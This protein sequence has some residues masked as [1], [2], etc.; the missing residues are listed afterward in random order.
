MILSRGVLLA[1]ALVASYV[2]LS[3]VSSALVVL[4]W[5][6]GWLDWSEIPARARA[7]RLAT[8]RLLPPAVIA[9][10]TVFV[11]FPLFLA[12]EPANPFEEVG[13]ALVVVA[14]IGIG[15]FVRSFILALRIVVNTRFIK[16][17]WLP[18]A[19]RLAVNDTSGVSA[20]RV[21]LTQPVVALVGIWRPT[22]VVARVVADACTD[23][24][25]A[26]MLR[27]ERTHFLSHD[28]LKRL[29]ITCAPDV[30]A[31]TRYHRILANAWHD[32]AEDAADDAA[33]H[34][35]PRASM[36]LAA[37]LLKIASLAPTPTYKSATI[38]PFI[39]ADGLERRV[40]RLVSDHEPTRAKPS[41]HLAG[42]VLIAIAVAGSLLLFSRTARGVVHMIVEF[43]VST[44]ATG[45]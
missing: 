8:L 10:L 21:E 45:R 28:N 44:G 38:S 2:A 16:S 5:K 25:M 17:V 35:D 19:T 32:A 29:L 20:Y 43:V 42:A 22:F 14:L 33:T 18:N 3:A 7:G 27:H 23:K 37:L 4:L 34:G 31:L 13:P 9:L 11:V 12:E 39:E 36:E 15:L 1:T 30:L 26:D 6:S 41:D 40:R 24:E